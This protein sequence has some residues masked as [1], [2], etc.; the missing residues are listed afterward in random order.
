MA[1]GF[2]FQDEPTHGA[3]NSSPFVRKE[4]SQ[5]IILQSFQSAGGL[6]YLRNESIKKV[7][8]LS[9]TLLLAPRPWI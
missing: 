4:V 2:L 1:L 8:H 6:C 7:T 3:M 5:L 9:N